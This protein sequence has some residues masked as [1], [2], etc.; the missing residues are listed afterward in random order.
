LLFSEFAGV[1]VRTVAESTGT[2]AGVT[3]ETIIFRHVKTFDQERDGR[4]T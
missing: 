3:P 1:Y 2:D 4:L